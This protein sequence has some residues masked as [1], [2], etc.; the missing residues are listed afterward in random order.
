M[1][2]WRR[3]VKTEALAV[4]AASQAVT[5]GNPPLGKFIREGQ[6]PIIK[7]H[8]Y[9]LAAAI[10]EAANQVLPTEL[11]YN[12]PFTSWKCQLLAVADALEAL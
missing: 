5:E 10:R 8:H 6:D 11:E 9:I 12:K 3:T 1:P 2:M 4:L 7:Q